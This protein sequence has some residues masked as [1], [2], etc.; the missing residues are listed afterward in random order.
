MK[1]AGI[2]KSIVGAGCVTIA[3]MLIYSGHSTVMGGKDHEPVN[4]Q[5]VS[6]SISSVSSDKLTIQGSI[7][8]DDEPV[9]TSA[10][11]VDTI[12]NERTEVVIDIVGDIMPSEYVLENYNDLGITGIVSQD[13]WSELN[14]A[15]IFLAN[16]EFPFGTTG[17]PAEDKQYTFE[18]EPSYID[19]FTDMGIDIV[20][21]ANN[22]ALDYG[23]DALS[24]TFSILDAAGI[25]R[26][27]AGN[28]V[29]EASRLKVIE[30]NGMKIGFLAGTRVIPEVS[31]NIEN[32]GPGLLATYD[33]DL[34]NAAISSAKE[35][36]DY[37]IVYVHWGIERNTEPEAYE[38]QLAEGYI[39]NG[40]DIVVGSHPHV[41][42][43]IDWYNG[44][45]IFYSMGNFIF[46]Q[47]IDRTMI[48]KVIVD[49]GAEA[50]Y[51][52]LPAKAESACTALVYGEERTEAFDYLESISYVTDIDEDGYIS[53]K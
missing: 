24:E 19:I 46:Y 28:D 7:E 25:E 32:G 21:L 16:Q 31:W 38:R 40:A 44:R 18:I 8:L 15:D 6:Q 29:E 51:Q 37:L 23:K 42:Q 41:I 43:G 5:D 9:S 17:M 34:L 36:C 52:I 48:L 2:L 47:T 30:K 10:G 39:D 33:A 14:G 49:E 45:P 35:N 26:I 4:T 13:V 1:L 20:T 53:C 3:G 22:H 27:G 12:E 50:R 11:I